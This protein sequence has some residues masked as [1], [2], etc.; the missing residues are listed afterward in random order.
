MTLGPRSDELI[1]RA[2]R[3]NAENPR[4]WLVQGISLHFT[5]ALFGGSDKESL[6]SLQRSIELFEAAPTPPAPRPAWGHAEAHAWAGQVLVELGRRGEARTH[7]ERAL[8][9]APH[10][11]WV[12]HVLLP[13]LA[14][15]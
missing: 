6:R 8:A 5:P 15:E 14:R 9:I 7:Y 3:A 1:E 2:L 12:K 4:A 13:A 11:G 10:Y